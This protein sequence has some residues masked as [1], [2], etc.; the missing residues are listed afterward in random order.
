MIANEQKRL[1]TVIIMTQEQLEEIGSDKLPGFPWDPRVPLI[2]RMSHYM[3][4]QV[5][6]ESHILHLGLVWSGPTGT[7]PMA[8][9]E[10]GSC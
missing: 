8:R 5:A 7:C 6:P 10:E 4:A 1:L 2:S 9:H 3:M